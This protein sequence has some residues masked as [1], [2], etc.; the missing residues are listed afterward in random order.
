MGSVGEWIHSQPGPRL[1]SARA[2]AVTRD[3]EGLELGRRERAAG[4]DPFDVQHPRAGRQL[5]PAESGPARR[6]PRWRRPRTGSRRAGAP[7]SG[8]SRGRAIRGGDLVVGVAV[9]PG[10]RVE[11]VTPPRAG[12]GCRRRQLRTSA[13]IRSLNAP[14]ASGETGSPPHIADFA[15]EAARLSSSR[16]R[17]SASASRAA[18]ACST[19]SRFTW[20]ASARTAASRGVATATR[21]GRRHPPVGPFG[22]TRRE[23]HVSGDRTTET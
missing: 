17:R 14:A 18:R 13:L 4:V 8:G 23:K 9:G 22:K 12:R 7:A 1:P 15:A 21:V 5:R 10:R 3:A 19:V 6:R 16:S 20:S 11:R 2:G